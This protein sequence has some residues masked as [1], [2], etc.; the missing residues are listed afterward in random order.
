LIRP[1]G[2]YRVLKGRG[3]PVEELISDAQ[4]KIHTSLSVVENTVAERDYLLGREFTAADI[5]MGY[6]VGLLE[7][8]MGDRYPNARAYLSRVSSRPAYQSVVELSANVT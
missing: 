1:L 4:D 7:R 3:K 5:M 8:L 6:S 2:V